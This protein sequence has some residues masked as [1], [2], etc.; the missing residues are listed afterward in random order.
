MS[1]NKQLELALDIAVFAHRNVTR[2]DGDPYIFHP[3]RVASNTTYIKTKK[4]KA[5]ALLHDVLEDTPISIPFLH[6]KGVSRDITDV[7]VLLTHKESEDYDTY[8]KNIATNIDAMLVKLADL[9]DN[10]RVET[11]AKITEKE[12]M[13]IQKYKNAKNFILKQL[14]KNHPEW[15]EK[16]QKEGLRNDH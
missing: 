15:F 14:E 8:I 9:E 5:V 10:L 4:Q 3:L 2:Q 16:I 7:L 12:E 13:R 6:Q 1:T 11:L